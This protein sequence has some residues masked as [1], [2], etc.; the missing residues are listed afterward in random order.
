MTRGAALPA[1]LFALA[2]TS[3]LAVGGLY[4][5]RR[6]KSATL[7][8]AAATVLRPSAESAAIDAFVSWD[9]V[10]RAD[11]LVGTTVTMD[12][13]VERAVWITRTTDDQY[14]IVSE[15]RTTRSPIFYHRVGLSVVIS[16]GQR[17]LP[18]PRAWSLLP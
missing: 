3:A 2:L 18:Y 13:T 1:T 5:A 14:L 10:A 9:S 12:S 4:V 11:Q 6:H 16:A 8:A 7:D 17:R 15:A